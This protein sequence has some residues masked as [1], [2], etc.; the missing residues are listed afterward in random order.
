MLV[1]FAL[2]V[3]LL[4][5]VGGDV[6]L[7][8][9]AV[10]QHE[11]IMAC[12][13]AIAGLALHRPRPAADQEAHRLPGIGLGA[14]GSRRIRRGCREHDTGEEGGGRSA[15]RQSPVGEMRNSSTVWF[16]SSQRASRATA[17]RS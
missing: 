17:P 7:L 16:S 2:L 5:W 8:D 3:L 15:H 11:F 14:L 12:D 10:R 4:R 13:R 1:D 9:E 6:V